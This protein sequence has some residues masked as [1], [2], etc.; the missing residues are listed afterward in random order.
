MIS[1]GWSVVLAMS[2]W[3]CKRSQRDQRSCASV[4]TS[5]S[6]GPS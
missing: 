4:M 2:P 1:D 3:L 5:T 6:A